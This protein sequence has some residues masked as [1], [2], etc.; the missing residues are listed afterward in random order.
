M[1]RAPNFNRLARIY[2]WL[3]WFTFGPLLARCRFTFLDDLRTCRNALVLGDG[4]GR[5]TARL[6]AENPNVLV[7]AVD[8]SDAMLRALQ[9]NAG[10]NAARVRTHLADAR[11][12]NP[13]N[14]PYDLVATHFFLDCLSTAEVAALA[15]RLRTCITPQAQWVISDFAIPDGAFGR[16]FAQP[17]IAALYTAFRILTGLGQSSL[18]DYCKALRDARFTLVQ[19]RT[20]FGG[21]L[22]SELWVTNEARPP[23]R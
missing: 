11:E 12:W 19:H 22:V 23:L 17:L 2:R 4:D 6:L 9:R 8:A 13:T 1:N 15:E 18:P 14:A 20:I 10:A 5:F 21:L 7:D 16:L 3:E